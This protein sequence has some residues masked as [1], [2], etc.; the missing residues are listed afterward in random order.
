MQG[1]RIEDSMAD[2]GM[3][4]K[5]ELIKLHGEELIWLWHGKRDGGTEAGKPAH[6]LVHLGQNRILNPDSS[7]SLLISLS[8]Y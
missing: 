4:G 8:T 1:W 2:S 6:A 3:K 7:V 5:R